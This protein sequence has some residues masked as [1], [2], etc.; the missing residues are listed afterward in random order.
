MSRV[1]FNSFGKNFRITTFGESHGY[2]L[3]VVV[4]GIPPRLPLDIEAVQEQLDRRRPGR[5]PLS[6]T[7][8]EPD[9]VMVFSGLMDGVTTGAPLTMIVG[10]RDARPGAYDH[11]QEVYR[12]GHADFT[13]QGKYGLRDWRG[14]GRSSGR[15]TVARV[16]A[17]AV[18]AQLLALRGITVQAH[19]V[20]VST[21]RARRYRPEVVESNPLR[22]G[23]ADAAEA[24]EDAILSARREGDSVGGVVQLR[25]ERIPPVWLDPGQ[26][27]VPEL[28]QAL[29]SIGAVKGVSL[30]PTR[31]P[32]QL[33][34]RLAVKPTPSISL[35]QQTVNQ[36]GEAVEVSI[37]GRH[38]PCIVPR[39]L[40]VAEAMAALVLADQLLADQV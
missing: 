23:D 1:A 17:G 13:T 33:R 20:Q 38:D 32:G 5:S 28:C 19:T 15:E 3:G 25:M 34:I 35:P 26:P 39:I 10:N 2:G 16:A 4:E 8:Q 22:C 7:R 30:T 37:K 18:A 14:G 9:R 27:L 40:P 31:A 11:L 21:I 24:M 12:P 29:M 36:A 6:S